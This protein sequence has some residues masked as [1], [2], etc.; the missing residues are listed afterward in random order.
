NQ[1]YW[2][3]GVP[4]DTSWNTQWGPKKIRCDYAWNLYQGD[5]SAVV[6]LIDTGV[7]MNH[8]DLMN[9]FAYGYDFYAMD[10]NPDDE[11]G[12]GSHT[13]GIAAGETNNALGIAGVSNM[14]RFAAYRTGN[15]YLTDDAI[16]SSIYDAISQGALVIS[17]SFGSGSPSTITET[18]LNDAYNAGVVCVASAG[19]NGNTNY[20]YPAAYSSVM[21]VASTTS[22]DQRSSFSTYG[23]WVDVAAPGSNIISTFLDGKYASLNG[24]SMACPHVAGMAVLLYSMIGGERTKSHADQIR[25]LIQNTCDYVGSWVS[26]GRVNLES[27]VMELAVIEPPLVTAVTPLE[28][29][30]YQNGN[31][32]LTGSNLGTVS[33]IEISDGTTLFEGSGF[34]IVSNEKIRFPAP[35]AQA[36]GEH[37]LMVTNPMGTSGP[38]VFTYVETYPPKISVPIFLHQNEEINWA[39]AGMADHFYY[40]IVGTDDSI[41]PIHGLPVMA[42]HI[43]IDWGSL[44]SIGL[45]HFNLL[46]DPDLKN[47]VFYSQLI[48]FK[49]GFAAVTGL[50][51]SAILPQ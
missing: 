20:N 4:N 18:A 23:S 22:T 47:I 5:P 9:K 24:T 31:I 2:P 17:M 49:D 28:V 37:E 32:T 29:K 34:S 21:S 41:F 50:A 14:C 35:T 36:L 45:G 15:Y 44:D 27:A 12:H 38:A 16:I 19:N 33:K 26:H 30:A 3:T 42:N 46:P 6:A 7:D 51:P 10:G 1:I 8:P 13:S 11:S 39:F 48:T 40:L 25:N 43:M